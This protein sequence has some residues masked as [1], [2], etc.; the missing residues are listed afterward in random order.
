MTDNKLDPAL[1][2][3][4]DDFDACALKRA[5][6]LLPHSTDPSSMRARLAATRETAF[7]LGYK[8]C[9]IDGSP[10][11]KLLQAVFDAACAW[12]DSACIPEARAGEIPDAPEDRLIAAIDA[13]RKAVP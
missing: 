1:Q 3:I 10:R 11:F 9:A 4:L 13:A 7:C 6:E 2:K 12:R 5:R 8:A